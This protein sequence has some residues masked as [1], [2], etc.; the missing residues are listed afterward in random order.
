MGFGDAIV[1]LEVARDARRE[2]HIEQTTPVMDRVLDLP[3]ASTI[4]SMAVVSLNSVRGET[5]VDAIGIGT[6]ERLRDPAMAL[7]Q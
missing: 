2:A 1:I 3:A 7:S 4:V 5:E 6:C